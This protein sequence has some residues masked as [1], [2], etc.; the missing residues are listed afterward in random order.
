MHGPQRFF[1]NHLVNRADH[2]AR[3]H[4]T[5]IPAALA[6]R[7]RRI[8]LRQYV[9]RF[10]LGNALLQLLGFFSG[11]DQ[12]VAGLGFHGVPDVSIKKPRIMPLLR[13]F[14]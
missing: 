5:Q 7:A 3:S 9:K 6:A 12:N 4:F 2:L 8:L 1:E 13:D 11:L 10:A 14:G